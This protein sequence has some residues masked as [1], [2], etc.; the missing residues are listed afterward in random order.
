MIRL[1]VIADSDRWQLV[2][3]KS[4][5]EYCDRKYSFIL[6]NKLPPS[7]EPI[8][9]AT[10]VMRSYACLETGMGAGRVGVMGTGI[11]VN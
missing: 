5:E 6:K 2:L 7:T 1:I 4:I 10:F 3:V 8:D 9:S 11:G